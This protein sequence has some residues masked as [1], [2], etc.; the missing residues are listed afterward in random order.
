MFYWVSYVPTQ[1][2]EYNA[3]IIKFLKVIYGSNKSTYAVG[4]ALK[5]I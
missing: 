1:L 5:L 2:A 4:L 3:W